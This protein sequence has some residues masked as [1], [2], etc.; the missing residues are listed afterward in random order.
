MSS[1]VTD[2]QLFLS[3]IEIELLLIEL[4]ENDFNMCDA[5]RRLG[6]NMAE[7]RAWLLMDI[8]DYNNHENES[9]NI[10]HCQLQGENK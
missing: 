1:N 6:I 8:F 10:S 2:M 3:D 9:V 7:H 4:Y 5:L